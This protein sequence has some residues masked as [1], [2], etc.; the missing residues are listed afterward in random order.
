MNMKP[1]ALLCT[2]SLAMLSLADAPKPF[3]PT[4][5]QP[6]N[7]LI[8]GGGLEHSDEY[9]RPMQFLPNW[10]F[11][12]VAVTREEFNADNQYVPENFYD[13]LKNADM[14]ISCP[15]PYPWMREQNTED[16][17]EFL[18]RGGMI[19][20]V[21]CAYPSLHTWCKQ[22]GPD[23]KLDAGQ[24]TG[25]KMA[26]VN[27]YEPDAAI[28]HFPREP[29]DGGIL[30]YHFYW[31]SAGKAWKPLL[32]CK[33][34]DK[35]CAAY[36]RYGKGCIVLTCKRN[37]YPEFLENMR[38]FCEL[39]R[40]GMEP[41]SMTGQDFADGNGTLE[42]S[43]KPIDGGEPLRATDYEGILEITPVDETVD[44]DMD[45]TPDKPMRKIAPAVAGKD[46]TI[47]FSIPYALT[48]RGKGRVRLM[49]RNKI[50]KA[51]ITLIDRPWDLPPLVTFKTPRYRS[52]VSVS[53]RFNN[54]GLAADLRIDNPKRFKNAYFDVEVRDPNGRS[55]WSRSKPVISR[56]T[57]K[58]VTHVNIPLEINGD[59]TPG[60]YTLF[61]KVKYMGHEYTN[62]ATLH[63]LAPKPGQV[64]IDEDNTLLLAGKPWFPL[65]LYHVSP[66][67]FTK[68]VEA[69][70]IDI[71]Q[72]SYWWRDRIPEVGA[73]GAGLVLEGAR[74]GLKGLI[75]TVDKW[76]EDPAVRFWYVLDEPMDV[77][78]YT[79]GDI[80]EEIHK[81]DID[82]PTYFTIY[83]PS[84]GKWMRQLGDIM[85]MDYYPINASTGE[86]DPMSIA[87]RIDVI[88]E[89]QSD[90]HPVMAVLQSFGT[91]PEDK[92]RN[93]IYM[94]IIH[95]AKGIIWYTWDQQGA[96][97]A[98][99]GLH[100]FPE[101]QAFIKR[102]VGEIKS[103]EAAICS[104]NVKELRFMD[105]NVH[106]LL[107]GTKK[108]GFYL[109]IGNAKN[110][111][112]DVKATG[113]ALP[114]FPAARLEPVTDGAPDATLTRDKGLAL[115][116]PPYGT[117]AYRLVPPG[118]L[119]PT[120]KSAK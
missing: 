108:T 48:V 76:R 22:L 49:I 85:A 29:W 90:S 19:V 41:V 21:D 73:A 56:K 11:T 2:V 14:L 106:A 12:K 105:G 77:G 46:G 13:E 27:T 25:T 112:I 42:F 9:D 31:W 102:V 117:A 120:R 63:V 64:V 81:H 84:S 24:G 37:P 99:A 50:A 26:L 103:M 36:A 35:P 74:L 75:Q 40:N 52:I 16:I 61:A 20:Q 88:R 92:M 78:A 83:Y 96:Y 113:E 33:L 110:E 97:P 7:T 1:F 89:R 54:V 47:S 30:W 60:D 86:G 98:H 38:A 66:E 82:H 32:K 80:N 62:S 116:L 95:M 118:S 51:Y 72:L 111:Y 114:G 71:M 104:T 39:I 8:A 28:R 23:W 58:P 44:S 15:L 115:T 57:M 70:G 59:S 79:G 3:K 4:P 93:M 87:R 69:T 45:G 6:F 55:V 94:S 100:N 91:E 43:V 10:Q 107:C 67:D 109:I 119:K 17:K 5:E 18:N 101:Q 34:H 65:G 53:N 68:S